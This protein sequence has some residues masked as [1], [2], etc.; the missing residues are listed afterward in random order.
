M[1]GVTVYV[2]HNDTVQRLE[3]NKL[4]DIWRFASLDVV[5]TSVYG[6]YQWS[7]GRDVGRQPGLLPQVSAHLSSSVGSY[8]VCC[9]AL[10]AAAVRDE[11]G[12]EVIAAT[13]LTSI[14]KPARISV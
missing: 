10:G 1:F 5:G 4:P 8:F 2:T 13:V 14:Q 9:P 3:Y 7:V 11:R 6:L 12:T